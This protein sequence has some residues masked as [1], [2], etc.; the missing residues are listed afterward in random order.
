MREFSRAFVEMQEI[1]RSFAGLHLVYRGS[2]RGQ[3][4]E[5]RGQLAKNRD[6][7]AKSLIFTG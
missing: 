5:S 3:L 6:F 4:Q 7:I 2:R 1:K